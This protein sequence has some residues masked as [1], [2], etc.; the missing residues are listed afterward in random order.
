MNSQTANAA[1]K[2]I[3]YKNKLVAHGLRSIVSTALNEEGFNAD[4][5]ESL[6]AH[7][8]KMKS[9]EHITVQLTAKRKNKL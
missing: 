5:I 9:E 1:L 6:L 7:V 2:R 8:E 3:G 4:A